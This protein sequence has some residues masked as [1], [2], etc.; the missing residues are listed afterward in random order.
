VIVLGMGAVLSVL[1]LLGSPTEW[2]NR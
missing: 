2:G 1:L